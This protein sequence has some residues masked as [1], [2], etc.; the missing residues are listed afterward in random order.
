MNRLI[1]VICSCLMCVLCAHAQNAPQAPAAATQ[2]RPA[3]PVANRAV[4]NGD[5]VVRI[6]DETVSWYRMLG[7]QQ[8]SS[9][10]PSDLL[11][12]YANRQ[13]ADRVVQL[14]FEIA[15][16]NA[17]LLSSQGELE[18]G[19]AAAAQAALQQNQKDLDAR[20]ESIQSEIAATQRQL[21]AATPAERGELQ[22]KASELQSELDLVNARRN[23]LKTMTEFAHANGSGVSALK[24]HINAIAA[25]IPAAAMTP[26]NGAVEP[27]VSA[28]GVTAVQATAEPTT[29]SRF[30]IWDLASDVLRLTHKLA[31]IDEIDRR[32]TALQET[33]TQIRSA[34]EEQI[35][36]LTARGDE[37]AA[38]AGARNAAQLK[39]ARDEYD[40]LAWLFD[41]TSAILIP[42]AKVG[43][44]L[45]QYHN[46]LHSWRAATRAQYLMA[47]KTLAARAALLLVILGVVIAAGEL[48]K[49]A[50]FR[51]AQDTRRRHQLLLVRRFVLWTVALAIIGIAFASE[52]S[53][54]ATFAGLLTA[55]VAVA[56]QSVL[57]SIV[58]YFFLI[59]KYGLRVGDRVQIG[60]VTGEVIDVGLVRLHMM[61]LGP[62]FGAT[63]RVV[64]F[65][66]SVVFQAS[67]GLF[68]Q[69]PGVNLAWRELTLAVPE[70]ADYSAV[71]QRLLEAA[72]HVLAD[73]RDEIERQ[74]REL[75]RT[76]VSSSAERT[77][78]Y[79][80]LRFAVR[81]VD[82]IVRY[83]V[84][85]QRAAEVDERMSRELLDAIRDAGGHAKLT[86][87]PT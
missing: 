72:K 59:G 39:T 10:Q 75:R 48:W 2:A 52:A 28:P 41:Q 21:A 33:F 42:L 65:A 23:L 44:L 55:G 69:I 71:K 50:V 80:Q 19:D 9:T 30:G 14:A 22:T 16:A 86:A 7:V 12:L 13:T 4:M 63:G 66:N 31:T 1:A 64:A 34:P 60:G 5:Q 20:R 70:G 49:R 11:I 57:V 84:P 43:V 61:E 32:T 47:W 76:S 74:A 25:S 35:K 36:T 46:N 8:Q 68:K 17:E 51:Y 87:Q 15:R 81:S 37:I 3:D 27:M 45:D 29:G 58:G 53:S 79:V 18:Q 24:E 85:M 83:P 62:Q 78:P 38:L 6:L 73:Y 67:G 82:A 54:F 56:M 26:E 77:D 40:T